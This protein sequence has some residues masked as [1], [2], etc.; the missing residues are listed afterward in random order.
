[1]IFEKLSK[2]Q[3]NLLIFGHVVLGLLV[4]SVPGVMEIW[5]YGILGFS[6]ASLLSGQNKNEIVT[7]LLGYF[8]GMEV[9]TRMTKANVPWEGVKYIIVLFSLVALSIETRKKKKPM[10]IMVYFLLLLPSLLVIDYESFDDARKQISFNLSGPLSML[11]ATFYFYNRKVSL[12]QLKRVLLFIVLPMI[13]TCVVIAV[14]IPSLSEIQFQDAANFQLSGGYGPNQVSS[15]LGFGV[16]VMITGYFLEIPISSSTRIDRIITFV[17]FLFCAI[18]FSR[19]GVLTTIAS[20][21]LGTIVW[22]RYSKSSNKNAFIFTLSFIIIFS[23]GIFVF[24]DSYTGNALSKRY[25]GSVGKKDPKYEQFGSGLSGREDIIEHDIEVFYMYPVLGVGPGMSLYVR[26]KLYDEFKPPHTEFSRLLS[27]HG[28][29]GI[30]A[31]LLSIIFPFVGFSRTKE[32]YA[33]LFLIMFTSYSVI[34]S[35]H[36]AMRIAMMGFAY[37]IAFINL[38]PK[39]DD[40]ADPVK[41]YKEKSMIWEQYEQESLS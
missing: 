6:M 5:Y 36:S 11:L 17:L 8:T 20:V 13:A 14:R 34:C 16:V 15:L 3:I 24:F 4:N 10:M 18:N 12:D 41:E 37:G 28:S 23:I 21:I 31:L 27:E 40:L 7:I 38:L 9:L 32:F 19:G 25:A 1:M 2:F 26:Q 35:F 22:I 33:K 29:L 30:G 39:R